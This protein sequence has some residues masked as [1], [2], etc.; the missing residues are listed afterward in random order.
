LVFDLI[1]TAS[2]TLNQ[3]HAGQGS[4]DSTAWQAWLAALLAPGSS[5]PDNAAAHISIG[6]SRLHASWHSTKH[7]WEVDDILSTPSPVGLL[8]LLFVDKPVTR[9][10]A[11]PVVGNRT[12]PAGGYHRMSLLLRVPQATPSLSF[13]GSNA[14]AA[15]PDQG[16]DS[17]ATVIHCVARGCWGTCLPVAVAGVECSTEDGSREF[18][19]VHDSRGSTLAVAEPGMLVALTVS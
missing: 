6:S 8:T 5:M 4:L 9:L 3:P 13:L 19:A 14:Q 1:Q 11:A 16:G 12:Q 17:K 10:S 7:S 18:H 15:A 2:G